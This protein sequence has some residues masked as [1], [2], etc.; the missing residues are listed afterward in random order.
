MEQKGGICFEKENYC[1]TYRRNPS[2]G[3]GRY[4]YDVETKRRRRNYK[5]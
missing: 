5:N 1:H 3:Y 4:L 2:C